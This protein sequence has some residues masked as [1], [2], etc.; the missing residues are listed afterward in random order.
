MAGK[1]ALFVAVDVSATM[2]GHIDGVKEMLIEIFCHKI[3]NSKQA[4]CPFL[5]LQFGLLCSF[6]CL[7]LAPGNALV[8]D[9]I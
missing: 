5:F 6:D 9:G 2:E 7:R 4:G 8:L 1:E 3:A